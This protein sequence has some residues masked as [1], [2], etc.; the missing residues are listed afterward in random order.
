M[1]LEA[2]VENVGMAVGDEGAA[3][4]VLLGVRDE[5]LPIFVGPEQAQT[6]E[7]ARQG[8]PAPRPMTHDLFVGVVDDLGG[9]VDR[10]RIT[11]LEDDTFY[12]KLDLTVEGAD[13]SARV[14]R[15]ARPS[16][17]IAL[18]VRVGCPITVAE[19][20]V[21][22]AGQDP[23]EFVAGGGPASPGPS[24]PLDLDDAVDIDIDD[25]DTDPGSEDEP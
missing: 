16:D 22:E 13:G 19:A 11:D 18:A 10:V 9:S 1:A 6:I 17:G 24:E 23:E 20:V 25:P 7:R 4:V 21:D 12:A 8:V 2:T 15:D 5:T 3:G 14:V